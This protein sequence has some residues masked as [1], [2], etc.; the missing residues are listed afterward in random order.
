MGEVPACRPAGR[1]ACLPGGKAAPLIMQRRT[2][3]SIDPPPVFRPSN[4]L[5][6]GASFAEMWRACMRRG[7][8]LQ[9]RLRDVH[10][11]RL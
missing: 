11:A 2:C 6:Y 5:R 8:T 7:W 10:I 3:I 4:P 9:S 1:P